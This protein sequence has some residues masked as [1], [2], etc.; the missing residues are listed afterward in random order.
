M[1]LKIKIDLIKDSISPNVEQPAP[2]DFVKIRNFCLMLIALSPLIYFI[3]DYTLSSGPKQPILIS[4][5][6]TSQNSISDKN[7]GFETIE[8]DSKLPI[9]NVKSSTKV[10]SVVEISN[11]IAIKEVKKD[12]NE[13][14][15]NPTNTIDSNT[16]NSDVV[17]DIQPAVELTKT[18][19]QKAAIETTAIEKTVIKK[20]VIEKTAIES[21]ATENIESNTVLLS[22]PA[23]PNTQFIDRAQLT[24]AIEN[25]EP[26]NNVEVL[27]LASQKHL[28][29]FTKILQK[30]NQKIYHRWVFNQTTM[31]QVALNIGSNQWR[32]SS[33]KNF[34]RTMV[35]QW[36]VQVLDEDEN[37]LKS[38]KFEVV[39]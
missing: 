34:D 16:V 36:L 4:P 21:T 20:T 3:V 30:K 35:G 14:N 23:V 38:I 12:L 13:A 2:Y 15:L 1:Q 26:I 11:V 28:Y 33:S 32:T 18:K 5:I 10:E 39:L 22:S 7:S 24:L 19:I 29:L 31:A 17:D 25:R 6:A 9:V 27:S 37:I 8:V